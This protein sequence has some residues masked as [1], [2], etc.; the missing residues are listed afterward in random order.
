M[1]KLWY[2][3]SIIVIIVDQTVKNIIRNSFELGES[4]KICGD[5]FSITY[6]RNHGAAFSIMSGER[7]ALTLIPLIIVVI[8]VFYILKHQYEHFTMYCAGGLLIG[9]GLANLIDRV[10]LGYVTDMFD[11]HFWPVFN[12]ADIAI[13]TGCAVLMFYILFYYDS[14]G[15]SRKENTLNNEE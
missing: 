11:F 1:N 14:K 3:I 9:G 7:T 5:F 15:E 10:I 2:I 13:V 12:V 4:I 6:V 8:A